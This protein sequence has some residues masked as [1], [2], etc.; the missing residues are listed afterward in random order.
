MLI[1]TSTCS[2]SAAKFDVKC[3]DCN[4]HVDDCECT[5]DECDGGGSIETFEDKWS[6]SRDSHYTVDRTVEC[7]SCDGDGKRRHEG[8]E[9]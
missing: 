1:G 7:P 9:E 5:C 3:P 2:A 8:E 4:K 6:Y